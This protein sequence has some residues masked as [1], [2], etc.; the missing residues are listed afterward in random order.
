MRGLNFEKLYE[1]YI[2]VKNIEKYVD[3]GINNEFIVIDTIP[4]IVISYENLGDFLFIFIVVAMKMRL[5]IF[6]SF[7]GSVMFLW[8]IEVLLVF[9][10][11]KT[12]RFRGR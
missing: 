7:L 3:R 12:K 1:L 9:V 2:F 5:F 6:A 8:Q 4:R 10:F 11:I